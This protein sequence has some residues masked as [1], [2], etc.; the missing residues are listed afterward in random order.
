MRKFDVFIL[1]Y[2]R[3]PNEIK[4]QVLGSGELGL[5]TFFGTLFFKMTTKKRRKF[6]LGGSSK[7]LSAD[8]NK[9]Y[10]QRNIITSA[11]YIR[12]QYST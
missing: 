2:S 6:Q 4:K 5:A 8:L 7:G 10:F 11:Y 12:L 1:I 3:F 9:I